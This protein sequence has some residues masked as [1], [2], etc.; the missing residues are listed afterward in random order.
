[1]PHQ[2]GA[3]TKRHFARSMRREPTEAE[4]RLWHELRGR[5]L[6][7]IKFRRQVP[8]GK[9]IADFV[10]AGAR[11]IVEIDGSQ[12]ADS[13]YDRVRDA[14]LKARGFRVLR[15]WNDDV[16]RDLNAVCDT[17][18]AYVRDESLQPWR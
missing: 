2:P 14:E 15:F 1:M 16:L 12:H 18:I 11:L 7:R 6:D 4:D 17:I 3:P 5:R 8:V 13:N 9:F 10:C